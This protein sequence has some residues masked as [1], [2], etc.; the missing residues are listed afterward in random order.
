MDGC[1]TPIFVDDMLILRDRFETLLDTVGGGCIFWLTVLEQFTIDKYPLTAITTYYVNWNFLMRIKFMR[2]FRHKTHRYAL[3]Y[4]KR[5]FIFAQTF[6]IPTVVST[7]NYIYGRLAILAIKS[8][9]RLFAKKKILFFWRHNVQV[10]KVKLQLK[11]QQTIKTNFGGHYPFHGRLLNYYPFF[12]VIFFLVICHNF[13]GLF[14]YGFQ[15][16]LFYYKIL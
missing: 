5:I 7:K 3:R 4:F 16:Q 13:N 14:F 9:F 11:F 2:Y 1:I 12:V 8:Y 15:T 10:L 6:F